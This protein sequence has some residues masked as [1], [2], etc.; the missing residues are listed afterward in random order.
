MKILVIVKP[1]AQRTLVE[2]LEPGKFSVSVTEPP[3]QGRAN[4]AIEQALAE[5]FRVPRASVRI[6]LGFTS[7]QKVVA[8]DTE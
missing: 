6:V 1:N 2:E 8:V 4:R 7:R 3:V 5:H